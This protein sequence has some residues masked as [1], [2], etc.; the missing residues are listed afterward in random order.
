MLREIGGEKTADR[1]TDYRRGELRRSHSRDG[2]HQVAL[3]AVLQD[4]QTPYGYHHHSRNALHKTHDGK[5]RQ[6]VAERAQDGGG[7][8]KAQNGISEQRTCAISVGHPS[9]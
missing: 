7:T 2:V 5:L 4:G 8:N 1:R 9:R 6:A 3:V